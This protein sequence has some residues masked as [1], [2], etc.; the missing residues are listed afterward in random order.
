MESLLTSSTFTKNLVCIVVDEVHK[1][2][3]GKV[4]SD[5]EK[6]FTEAFGKI[7]MLRSL[8]RGKVPVLALSATID[9][10]LTN[11]VIQSCNL[12]SKL[13]KIIT[14]FSDRSNIRLTV[15][16]VKR[17]D[18]RCLQWIIKLIFE[19]KESCPKIILYCR[20]LKM[21]GWLYSKF[22]KILCGKMPE[23]QV[24]NI[25]SMFHSMTE[26]EN[27]DKILKGGYIIQR[28]FKL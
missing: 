23:K 4:S 14:S 26:E 11:L 8:C 20:T 5:S 9:F 6:P 18:V 24:K 22:F 1:I 27:K 10:D 15:K 13:N 17:K 19:Q 12:S 7:S 25:I 21:V 28:I 3:L 16:K 2:T